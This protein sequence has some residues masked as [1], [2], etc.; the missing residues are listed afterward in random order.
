MPVGQ[1]VTA[2][3]GAGVPVRVTASGR[4]R[5]ERQR[6]SGAGGRCCRGGGGRGRG[7]GGPPRRLTRST[8]SCGRLGLAQGVG[9]R[10]LD[11]RAGQLGEQLEVGGV[12][13]G[14][15]GDQEGEVGR[16]VLGAEVDRR[17][18]AGR[19]PASAPRRRR[20]GSAGSRCR[21]AG[22]WPRCASRARASSTSWST[23]VGAAGFGDDLGEAGSRR[24]CR[25]RGA[26]SRRTR[27]V[28]MRSDIGH[29][30]CGDR[31]RSRDRGPR[32]GVGPAWGAGMVVPG[33]PAAALP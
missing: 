1:A 6:R 31:S 19:R 8:T 16:A 26:A 9:E 5:A 10:R 30:P 32:L 7:R 27:S 4:R 29:S 33:S 21:R 23:S 25:R 18:T 13:A 20:C 3:S 28:V 12:A 22:R 11:Q 2:T 17:A 24:A 15:G 14:R